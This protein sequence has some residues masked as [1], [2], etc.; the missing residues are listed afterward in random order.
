MK[1]INTQTELDQ[2]TLAAVVADAVARASQAK[3]D[4]KRWV[5]AIA[6][7]TVELESNPFMTFNHDSHSLL[8]MSSTSG[9]T[10][11]SNGVCQ[12]PAFAQGFPCWH[13]AAAKLVV[14]YLERVQ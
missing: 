1:F 11:E 14:N 4:S 8:I 12:C 7:A 5:N 10:Y 2:E 13:R 3:K 6:R 9:M